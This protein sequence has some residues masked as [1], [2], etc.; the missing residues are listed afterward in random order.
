M[1]TKGG[2]GNPQTRQARNSRLLDDETTLQCIASLK[3]SNQPY[4]LR[5]HTSQITPGTCAWVTTNPTYMQWAQSQSPQLL[6]INGLPGYGKTILASFLVTELQNCGHIVLYFFCDKSNTRS[7]G[8]LTA[9]LQSLVLQLAQL[10]L[11]QQDEVLAILL[12]EFRMRKFQ[13]DQQQ[14]G[15]SWT[16]SDLWAT[17]TEMLWQLDSENKIVI[18]IDALDECDEESKSAGNCVSALISSLMEEPAPLTSPPIKALIT[19]R[20]IDSSINDSYDES[21]VWH[22]AF[23]I[24]PQMT[25]DDIETVVKSKVAKLRQVK[26]ISEKNARELE[27]SILQH[28]KGMFLWASLTI[29]QLRTA[30]FGSDTIGS[31]FL[32][33]GLNQLFQTILQESDISRLEDTGLILSLLMCSTRPLK[34]SELQLLLESYSGSKWD[35]LRGDVSLLCGPLVAI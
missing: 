1:S 19:C 2:H 21:S 7:S 23:E 27:E 13:T 32:P 18:I 15:F 33:L 31:M 35:G 3:T 12:G 6:W 30:R 5:Q 28:S 34:L 20:Q 29:S 24:T 10:Q 26:G 22:K 16:W 9:I 8:N 4:K 11:R 14:S 17:L 25:V